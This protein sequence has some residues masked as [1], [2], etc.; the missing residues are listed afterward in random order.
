MHQIVTALYY[1]HSYGIVH[2]DIKLESILIS[3]NSEE[4]EVK[5]G[6]FGFAKVLGPNEFR[7]INMGTLLYCAPEIVL[8]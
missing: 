8:G 7:E 5:I 1:L 6:S 4:V 2:G 3:D